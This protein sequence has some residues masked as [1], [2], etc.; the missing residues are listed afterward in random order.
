M[1]F[2]TSYKLFEAQEPRN[3]RRNY[4]MGIILSIN[5]D[6]PSELHVELP[7]VV[8]IKANVLKQGKNIYSS[9]LD[10]RGLPR[11][12]EEQ[13]YLC[14]FPGYHPLMS[15]LPHGD[16]FCVT[17][18]NPPVDKRLQLKMSGS[19]DEGDDEDYDGDDLGREGYNLCQKSWE[20]F[21]TL[22]KKMA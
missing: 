22:T 14:R 16:T 4:I 17:K 8:D 5:Q 15:C 7:G 6:T 19:F 20:S 13:I 12:N 3:N 11:T 18:K 10:L 21:S 9:V 2:R 1:V